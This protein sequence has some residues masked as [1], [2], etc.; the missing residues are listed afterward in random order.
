MPTEAQANWCMFGSDLKNFNIHCV[1]DYWTVHP[2]HVS[3]VVNGH[4]KGPSLP[5]LPSGR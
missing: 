4:T 1:D 2:L 3:Y 5:S